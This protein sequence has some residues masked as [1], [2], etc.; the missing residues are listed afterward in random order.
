MLKIVIR[1]FQ[2]NSPLLISY[3]S[4]MPF[5]RGFKSV[6]VNQYEVPNS[7]SLIN[8]GLSFLINNPL[9]DPTADKPCRA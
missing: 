8:L 7:Y 1:T 2:R 3:L 6:H 4:G 9:K 5:L